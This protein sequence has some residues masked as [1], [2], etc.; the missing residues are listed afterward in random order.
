MCYSGYSPDTGPAG[1]ITYGMLTPST[2]KYSIVGVEVLGTA[3]AEPP[4]YSWTANLSGAG[5]LT[6]N[7][8]P[9]FGWVAALNGGGQVS[10]TMVPA[11]AWSATLD[12]I[13]QLT[14]IVAPRL[15]W[16]AE[17]AGDGL[18]DATASPHF[19][20]T[21]NLDG[22]G[23]LAVQAT[24]ERSW[25]A[26]F[27][28]TGTLT[29]A[30]TIAFGW[31]ALAGAEGTL[32]ANTAPAFQW[33]APLDGEGT[34]T[35]DITRGRAWYLILTGSGNLAATHRPHFTWTAN[36]TGEG[37]LSD[38]PQEP[39]D[40]NQPSPDWNLVLCKWAGVKMDGT[41][42]TGRLKFSYNGTGKF[43]LDDD[44]ETPLSIYTAELSVQL[45][46]KTVL[47]AGT[48]REVGYAEIWLPASNDPDITGSGGTYTCT[49]VLDGS[50]GQPPFKF[51]D[52]IAAPD[53]TI[54][55]NKVEH[56]A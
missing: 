11:L 44:P 41:P 28:G 39:I 22:S 43:L 21:A 33:V 29:T 47:F 25:T 27:G 7:P 1:T 48:P 46:T 45:T 26:Q 12:G 54:W 35:A 51:V 23:T 6:G 52:D 34:L 3:A 55:L 9:S 24:T 20:W 14:A 56:A 32:T 37:T 2:Q 5:T 53:G 50:G 49:E 15:T 13:G 36:L 19:E 31:E 42:C 16:D 10:A 38:E 17:L 40:M 8:R 4:A 18:L 30:A